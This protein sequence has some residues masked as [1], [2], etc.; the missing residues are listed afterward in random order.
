MC[1]RKEAHQS[2]EMRFASQHILCLAHFMALN[3]TATFKSAT[4]VG[5]SALNEELYGSSSSKLVSPIY[6]VAPII[7]SFYCVLIRTNRFKLR[8]WKTH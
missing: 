6:P 7:D 5:G 1:R 4:D 3:E 2:R 8:Q